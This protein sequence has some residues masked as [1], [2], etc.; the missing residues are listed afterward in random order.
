MEN[1]LATLFADS[2]V[3]RLRQ[4]RDRIEK[5]VHALAEDQIWARG[6][7]NENAIGNLILHLEG[8]V[9]QWILGGV[10]GQPDHRVR[11]V[12]FSTRGDVS[13]GQ[14]WEKLNAT[15]EEAATV[16]GSLTGR[17]LVEKV[18]IQGYPVSKLEAVF[19]VVEH[20]ALHSGQIMFA[21]KMLTHQDLGFYKHLG[22]ITAP[23][24]REQTP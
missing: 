1:E 13:T 3:R 23:A 21:T 17:E 12:E 19:H 24:H 5:C 10:D 20:F 9:R 6:S 22:S 16:T 18:T 8:N 11:D 2:A 15:V 4:Y 7:E 14:M